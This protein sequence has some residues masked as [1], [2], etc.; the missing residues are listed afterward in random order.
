M[1]SPT[2]AE[3]LWQEA[4]S[5]PHL[6]GIA[7]MACGSEG[8]H[9]CHATG[10]YPNPNLV[11]A[12]TSGNGPKPNFVGHVNRNGCSGAGDRPLPTPNLDPSMRV[13]PQHYVGLYVGPYPS[14]SRAGYRIEIL[15]L[16]SDR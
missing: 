10:G 12:L 4:N 9:I 2:I 1:Q 13:D 5:K 16:K 7:I 14:A 11:L 3:P 6:N 15:P 8:E